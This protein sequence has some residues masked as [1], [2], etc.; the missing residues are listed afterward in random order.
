MRDRLPMR[1]RPLRMLPNLYPHRFV[2]HDCGHDFVVWRRGEHRYRAADD[3][4]ATLTQYVD[5]DGE[6]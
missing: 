1:F 3:G 4:G 2:C 5:A 6:E